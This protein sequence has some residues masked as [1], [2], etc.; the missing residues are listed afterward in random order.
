MAAPLERLLQGSVVGAEAAMHSGQV[1]VGTKRNLQRVEGA[2]EGQ[3]ITRL[4]VAGTVERPHVVKGR[5]WEVEARQEFFGCCMDGVKIGCRAGRLVPDRQFQFNANA[6]RAR[7][8]QRGEE[9]RIERM[10]EFPV[11]WHIVDRF[12]VISKRRQLYRLSTFRNNRNILLRAIARPY[13]LFP[14]RKGRVRRRYQNAP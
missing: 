5:V 1:L 8:A 10:D 2:V 12:P 11:V 3:F 9:M 4:G 6:P 14:C 13:T 7:A